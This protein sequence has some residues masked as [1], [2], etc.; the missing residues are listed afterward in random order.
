M[1]RI[2]KMVPVMALLAVAACNDDDSTSSPSPTPAA[3]PT[4]SVI[5]AGTTSEVTSNTS[6][7]TSSSSTSTTGT[8]PTT[9]TATTPSSTPASTVSRS[10][11]PIAENVDGCLYRDDIVLVRGQN[12]DP[13]AGFGLGDRLDTA[14]EF[15]EFGLSAAD[16]GRLL[17]LVGASGSLTAFGVGAADDPLELANRL[18]ETTAFEASPVLL[19][20]IGGHW[21][22]APGSPPTDRTTG[23]QPPAGVDGPLDSTV[24]V[25][26]TG[27]GESTDTP[28]WLADRV[29]ALD[30]L[31]RLWQSMG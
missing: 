7:V 14:P 31:A 1:R 27:Y 13:G 25:V 19:T 3:A 5:P 28:S 9:G 23:P 6:S 20:T 30:D 11:V 4:S 12:A 22:F 2:V 18:E 10:S 8:S 24:A 29:T 15:A 16:I 26:D 17:R 21:K